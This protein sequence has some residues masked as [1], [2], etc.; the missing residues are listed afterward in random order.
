MLPLPSA[1][2]LTAPLAT[3][4]LD[5]P[6]ALLFGAALALVSTRLLRARGEAELSRT[7]ALAAGW[8]V[9]YGLCVA[10][11]YFVHPDWMFAY[12]KDARDVPLVPTY[13]AFVLVLAVHGAAGAAGA[14][15]LIL[16]GK[17]GWALAVVLGA[18]LT[19][20]MAFYLQGRQYVTLGTYA[21]YHGG[22]SDPLPSVER[23][24]VAM[25]VSAITS[26]LG[27][28]YLFLGQ[29]QR[30]RGAPKPG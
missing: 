24:R 9:F 28:V 5:P 1:L 13:L 11:F 25:N 12:L 19:L 2:A 3:V 17:Q 18:A 7:I 21:E 23:M 4:I 15:A 14:G 20:G 26:A 29:L 27:A 22:R 30:A 8:S 6:T 16:R 10:W